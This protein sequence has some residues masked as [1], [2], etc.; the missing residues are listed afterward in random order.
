MRKLATFAVAA[1]LATGLAAQTATPPP[2]APKPEAA[3]ESAR[4]IDQKEAMKLV[5]KH[6]AVWVD[7]RPKESWEQGHIPGALSIPLGELMTRLREIP[8]GKM[9]ITYCA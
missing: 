1:I 6:K 3:L 7:V 2:P 9:I 8:P 4:R 5:K